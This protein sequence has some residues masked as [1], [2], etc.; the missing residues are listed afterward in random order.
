MIRQTI[1]VGNSAGVLL[2]RKYLGN[3]VEITIKSLNKEEIKEQI[4][5]IAKPYLRYIIGIYL[6]G[7]YARN[8]NEA[9]S[10]IDIVIV[11]T[12]QINIKEVKNYHI[13]CLEYNNLIKELGENIISIYPM[14]MEAEVILNEDL[15]KNLLKKSV[16]KKNLE[17][18]LK[19]SKSALGVIR[20]ALETEEKE[21]IANQAIIYSLMLRLREIY[22]AD[23]ILD[24]KI[25]SIKGL[26]E[27]AKRLKIIKK[28]YKAYKESRDKNKV[29][30]K[31]NVEEIKEGYE[32]V[33]EKLKKQEARI[34]ELKEEKKTI[35]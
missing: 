32:F 2:P 4:L 8:E 16:T 21:L 22:L 5:D 9:D 31:I 25:G 29:I 1:K 17:W 10:D 27:Y 6:V 3:L 26:M 30:T 33:K 14:L 7:S 34:N 24:K 11:T 28:L 12:K 18:H 19:T 20:K 15:L 23:C 13:I 35:R